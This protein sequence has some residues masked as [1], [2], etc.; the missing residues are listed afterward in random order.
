MMMMIIAAILF[1]SRFPCAFSAVAA[2]TPN[3][4]VSTVTGVGGISTVAV[5]P[6]TQ[7]VY[8]AGDN[9]YAVN[10]MD[11]NGAIST[12]AGNG[13]NGYADGLGS[14]AT[15]SNS[16]WQL[17]FCSSNGVDV[18]YIADSSNNLIRAM[19]TAGLVTTIAGGRRRRIRECICSGDPP[20][21]WGH[22]YA[23]FNNPYGVL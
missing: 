6:N 4:V 2:A 14:Y 21:L 19:T 1:T 10:V 15:F 23:S 8:M 5:D 22:I 11:A 9:M 12:I 3:Y 20:T 7:R 13:G 17:Y 16:I 18:I